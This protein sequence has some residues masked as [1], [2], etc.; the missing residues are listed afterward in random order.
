MMCHPPLHLWGID[1]P[2]EALTGGHR[3]TVLRTRGLP[4]DLV[5]KST[6]RSEAAIAWLDEVQGI[7]RADGL[8]VPQMH[9]S[10]SGHWIADGWICE[11][12]VEGVL[13]SP[14][15][16]P[17]LGALLARFHAHSQAMPQRPGFCAS[18]DLLTEVKGGDVDLTQMP[19]DLVA[20]CRAAWSAVQT[21]LLCVVHGDLALGN[22]LRDPRGRLWL[23]DWDECRRDL[24]LFD[25]VILG[26]LGQA[27]QSAHLAWE[28][29][30]CWH[31]EPT[32]ARAVAQKLRNSCA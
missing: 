27:A 13:I 2:L 1:A 30:C 31:L 11:S 14:V 5:F 10:L 28:V 8:H 21:E 16:A 20:L 25:Q 12:L 19:A 18:V 6:R 23:I 15:D 26:N 22:L 9:R 24:P 3:N 29:A 32:H 7:A 17:D 4:D